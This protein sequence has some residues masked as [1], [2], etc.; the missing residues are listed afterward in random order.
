[1]NMAKVFKIR[2]EKHVKRLGIP[3]R[4]LSSTVTFETESWKGGRGWKGLAT[5]TQWAF[6][7]LGNTASQISVVP[8]VSNCALSKLR[9]L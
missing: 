8:G 3:F 5:W 2:Q 1:M 4:K 6:S 7:V 9:E